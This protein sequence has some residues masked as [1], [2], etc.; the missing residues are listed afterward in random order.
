MNVKFSYGKTEYRL[1]GDSFNYILEIY[2][3]DDP[4]NSSRKY[5]NRIESIFDIILKRALKNSDAETLE[6]M[7]KEILKFEKCSKETFKLLDE[8][9]N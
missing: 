6:E 2:K 9:S 4:Q 7:Q 5:L 1:T 8:G 3:S